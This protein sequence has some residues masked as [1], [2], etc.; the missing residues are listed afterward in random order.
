MTT[1]NLSD[2][3]LHLFDVIERLKEGNDPKADPKDSISIERA[4]AINESAKEII[5]I[6]KVEVDA[7]K[8]IADSNTKS[9]EAILKQSGVFQLKENNE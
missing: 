3:R 8:I 4:K 6:A 9:A 5:N 2:L 1:T 7:I